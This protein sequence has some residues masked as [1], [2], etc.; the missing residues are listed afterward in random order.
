MPMKILSSISTLSQKRHTI[1]HASI[2][3]F[4]TQHHQDLHFYTRL[5]NFH[6]IRVSILQKSNI[7]R[8]DN[9]DEMK[10][11]TRGGF[12]SEE[13]E[14]KGEDPRIRACKVEL[15]EEL[16][17][18]TKLDCN[19][20]EEIQIVTTIYSKVLATWKRK[21]RPPPIPS[22]FP[23]PDAPVTPTATVA[24]LHETALRVVLLERLSPFLFGKLC[25]LCYYVHLMT[26]IELFA[27]TIHEDYRDVVNWMHQTWEETERVSKEV[28][29]KIQQVKEQR[30]V[31]LKRH[32][33][34]MNE[35]EI[36]LCQAKRSTLLELLEE[37][38]NALEGPFYPTTP[39]PD[40]IKSIQTSPTTSI[41]VSLDDDSSDTTD[42]DSLQSVDLELDLE[43]IENTQNEG[44]P[45]IQLIPVALFQN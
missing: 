12:T 38:K 16:A 40:P 6:I 26:R 41:T 27:T 11:P 7:N 30:V 18:G 20:K 37:K 3:G 22:A 36:T 34:R 31:A 43:S 29:T 33:K 4:E 35:L 42:C 5:F 9:F 17:H 21:L 1:L 44:T 14:R 23:S 39:R 28:Q 2:P 8:K 45:F 24:A 15:S 19:L 13:I 10:G 32:A 25:Q